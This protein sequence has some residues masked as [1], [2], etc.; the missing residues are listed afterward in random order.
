MTRYERIAAG[1]QV[2]ASD[3]GCHR[4]PMPGRAHGLC[5][6]CYDATPHGRVISGHRPRILGP[7]VHLQLVM[8]VEQAGQVT[9]A[10]NGAGLSMAEWIRRACAVGLRTAPET[11]RETSERT[12]PPVR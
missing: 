2:C 11:F 8:S 9:R 10:A 7:S 6:P 1:L 5:R 3:N 4:A 12:P